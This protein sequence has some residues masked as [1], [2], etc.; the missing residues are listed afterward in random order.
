MIV[1]DVLGGLGNQLYHMALFECLK[2]HYTDRDIFLQL[3]HAV[4]THINLN[5]FDSVLKNWNTDVNNDVQC[6]HSICEENL[7]PIDVLNISNEPTVLYG[8]FQTYKYITDSFVNKLSFS[9]DILEKYP[10]IQ[11]I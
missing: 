7:N 11:N 2:Q 9:D 8:Y 4:D 6:S 5:Y 3:K 10:N 1:I